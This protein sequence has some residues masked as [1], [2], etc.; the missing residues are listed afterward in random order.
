MQVHIQ[1]KRRRNTTQ[2]A[3][4]MPSARKGAKCMDGFGWIR[5][6]MEP[7][8]HFLGTEP[9]ME[10]ENNSYATPPPVSGGE[11]GLTADSHVLQSKK[12][13][14]EVPTSQVKTQSQRWTSSGE[15]ETENRI[16]GL[17]RVDGHPKCKLNDLK[18]ASSLSQS[19][20]EALF[21]SSSQN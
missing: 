20:N 17:D 12:P 15:V 5:L 8:G 10:E 2:Y 7:P 1:V 9:G 21:F 6:R 16:D 3:V 4:G 11:G 13:K 14:H 19:Y 18:F